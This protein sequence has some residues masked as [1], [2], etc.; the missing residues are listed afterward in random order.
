MQLSAPCLEFPE[1]LYQDLRRLAASHLRRERPGHTLQPTALVN[2]AYLQLAGSYGNLFEKSRAHFLALASTVMRQVLVHHARRRN[3][4][5]RGG[6]GQKV[7]LDEALALS[8]N[9]TPD[10]VAVD[11]ALQ[12]LAGVDPRKARMI[13]LRYFGGLTDQE[14]AEVMDVSLSTVGRDIRFGLALLNRSLR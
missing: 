4:V 9:Q 2:E 5:K 14:I 1:L 12:S 13:E 11:E 6:G 3:A 7:T 8:P 10:V